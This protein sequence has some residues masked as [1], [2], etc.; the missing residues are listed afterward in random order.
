M[1]SL[2]EAHA[3]GGLLAVETFGAFKILG[4]VGTITVGAARLDFVP[5]LEFVQA[6]LQFVCSCTDCAFMFPSMLFLVVA[7]ELV[8][9]AS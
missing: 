7:E 9:E 8:F 3:E 4:M 1:P 2:R 5:I 6:G